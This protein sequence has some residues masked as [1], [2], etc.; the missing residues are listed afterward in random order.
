VS[1]SVEY[2]GT[3]LTTQ[4][5]TTGVDGTVSIDTAHLGQNAVVRLKRSGYADY[6]AAVATVGGGSYSWLVD[7]QDYVGVGV[8]GLPATLTASTVYP[9]TLTVMDYGDQSDPVQASFAYAGLSSGTSSTTLASTPGYNN[10]T[11]ANRTRTYN[12]NVTAGGA[13][14]AYVLRTVVSSG[15]NVTIL[16]N[17][18]KIQ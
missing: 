15:A 7:Y 1:V 6:L 5:F 13:N 9:V 12:F 18:G 17:T 3:S 14:Q 10:A 2:P 16:N 8:S 11:G 4:T